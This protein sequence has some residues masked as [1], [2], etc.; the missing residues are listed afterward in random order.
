M[1]VDVGRDARGAPLRKRRARGSATVRRVRER[2]SLLLFR[3]PARDE[4]PALEPSS[5]VFSQAF[6]RDGG[7]FG[8]ENGSDARVFFQRVEARDQKLR[9]VLHPHPSDV[10]PH[11]PRALRG[12]RERRERGLHQKLTRQR[13]QHLTLKLRAFPRVVREVR[14]VATASAGAPG[15]D[16]TFSSP[17]RRRFRRRLPGRRIGP[18][19]SRDVHA[20]ALPAA[21]A[22]GERSLASPGRRPLLPARRR[23]IAL[24]LRRSRAADIPRRGGERQEVLLSERRGGVERRQRELK[25]VEGGH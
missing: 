18:R 14:T 4:S 23:L 21:A 5:R 7:G 25:G 3:V 9:A 20:V 6:C 17:R 19:A 13:D 11:I 24:R 16:F 15:G 8:F 22:A 12:G 10:R 2:V 1:R